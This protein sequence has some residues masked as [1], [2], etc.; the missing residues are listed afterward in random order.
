MGTSWATICAEVLC[1]RSVG[2]GLSQAT[3]VV[4]RRSAARNS[5][6]SRMR[7]RLRWP[8]P[9]R[10]RRPAG[11]WCR[12]SRRRP[13]F[14]SPPSPSSEDRGRRM[15]EGHCESRTRRLDVADRHGS[16]PFPPV[17][18]RSDEREPSSPP[19][20]SAISS[21]RRFARCG[22]RPARERTPAERPP[23]RWHRHRECSAAHAAPADGG[24]AKDTS[25]GGGKEANRCAA[26]PRPH[27]DRWGTARASAGRSSAATQA[28]PTTWQATCRRRQQP[29]HGVAPDVRAAPVRREVRL[30][31]WA[32]RCRRPWQEPRPRSG[33]THG[34]VANATRAS[35][36]PLSTLPDPVRRSPPRQPAGR[37]AALRRRARLRRGATG[38]RRGSRCR[39]DRTQFIQ[40]C[41]SAENLPTV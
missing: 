29:G 38:G 15:R 41:E 28:G 22:G 16:S 25:S 6:K 10:R 39:R 31:P 18:G 32:A 21:A 7:W 9:R 11:H 3:S 8:A 37:P 27:P 14:P 17:R 26:P 4:C 13:A 2:I 23:R 36:R 30:D 34:S 20:R 33:R 5:A 35:A 40:P 24:S 19:G 1:Q 12:L